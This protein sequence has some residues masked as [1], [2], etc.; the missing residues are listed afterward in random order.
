MY[1]VNVGVWKQYQNRNLSH[2]RVLV[3]KTIER[4]SAELHRN[5]SEA[6]IDTPH[7]QSYGH[8]QTTSD[9]HRK[10]RQGRETVSA[11]EG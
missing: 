1:N 10:L 6:F 2:R 9:M 8:W 7:L 11:S 3:Q 4:H 5:C